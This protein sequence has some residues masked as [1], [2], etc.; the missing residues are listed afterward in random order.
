MYGIR[1]IE[2]KEEVFTPIMDQ[3]IEMFLKRS[4]VK[5]YLIEGAMDFYWF[6][7]L[8]PELILT[9]D[10][11]KV[12]S[13]TVQESTF[14][15]WGK[16]NPKTGVVD[17][18]Y[19]SANWDRGN[20]PSDLA[21][22]S[23]ID[24]YYDAV[25]STRD[26]REYKYIYP[27]SYPTPGKIYYQLATWD[28]ARTSKWLGLA[29]KIPTFKEALLD[30][31]I[32]IKYHIEVATYWWTWKYPDWDSKKLEDRVLL[33]KK[34][35]KEFTDIMTGVANAGKFFMS[36]FHSD[37][38]SGKEYAGWKIT[39]INDPV[40]DG[41]Y[42]ED[43]QEASSHLLFALGVDATLISTVPGK[44]V[45]GGSGSDKREAFNMYI[46]LVQAH[47]D[48]ILEP[49]EFISDYNGWTARLPG[50]TWK[51]RNSMLQT[52]NNVTPSKRSTTPEPTDAVPDN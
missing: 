38:L 49:L 50:L 45:G 51:F 39:P 22:V 2:G 9:G 4:N 19:I 6:Y 14:S 13:I 40:K 7:N 3:E 26:R 17:N 1:S 37:P 36:A 11:K 35:L 15:R 41:K 20:N 28:T 42:I 16:Q 31:Q 30:N 23:V 10:R 48:I 25:E 29:K 21:Q 34:E 12:A 18:C 24:P 46:S 43:S 47:Q 8:F 33:M 5:R 27:L 32:S 52:L 44:G